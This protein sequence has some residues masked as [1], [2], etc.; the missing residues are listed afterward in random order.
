[1]ILIMLPSRRPVYLKRLVHL[2]LFLAEPGIVTEN[3]LYYLDC[4]DLGASSCLPKKDGQI[5]QICKPAY[6]V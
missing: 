4:Y 3:R 6:R 1:M 2:T 5:Y